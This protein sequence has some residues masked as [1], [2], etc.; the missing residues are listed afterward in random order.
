MHQDFVADGRPDYNI[1]DM[2]SQVRLLRKVVGT[3]SARGLKASG[4]QTLEERLCGEVAT[5]VRKDLPDRTTPY[6][7]LG[8]WLGGVVRKTAVQVFTTNY[9]L[10][11]EQALEESGLPFFDGFVGARKPFFD[12]RAIEDDVLPSRWTRLWKLHGS[13]NWC[14]DGGGRVLRQHD[15]AA[16]D[17]LLIHPSELKY[18]QSRRMPYLAML[19]RLRAF[20]RQ[21]SAFLVTAGYSFAD[22]HLNELIIQGLRSNPTAA[23]FGLLYRKLSEET[24][25]DALVRRLPTNLALLASDQG[26]VRGTV[27]PWLTVPGGAAAPVSGGAGAAPAVVTNDLGDFNAFAQFLQGLCLVRGVPAHA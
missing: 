10:L 4:L 5:A 22:E 17:G 23:A 6:H 19:D 25:A 2:L 16:L 26:V 3:G 11:I 24:A 7:S 9:D 20:L 18:D 15:T 1:E 13:V 27:G 21:P 8:A 14:L 12:L